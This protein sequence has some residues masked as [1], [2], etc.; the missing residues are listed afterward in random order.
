M[1]DPQHQLPQRLRTLSGDAHSR[2]IICVPSASMRIVVSLSARSRS[3][4]DAGERVRPNSASDI[5]ADD[6]MRRCK[7]ASSQL[8]QTVALRS[9]HPRSAAEFAAGRSWSDAGAGENR[10]R[11]PRRRVPRIPAPPR[12]RDRS[13]LLSHRALFKSSPGLRDDLGAYMWEIF[14]RQPSVGK[15]PTFLYGDRRTHREP[16]GPATLLHSPARRAAAARAALVAPA[17]PAADSARRHAFRRW[18]TCCGA[19]MSRSPRTSC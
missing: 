13:L 5:S 14:P 10:T 6:R 19:S 16:N 4:I 3:D 12:L 1:S 7:S 11:S 2:R 8:L 9:A 17:G 18:R 15:Y